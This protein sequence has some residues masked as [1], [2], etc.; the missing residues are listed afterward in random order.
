MVFCCCLICDLAKKTK[1][2]I[3]KKRNLKKKKE[4]KKK[5][6]KKERVERKKERVERKKE[7]NK[8]TTRR[9][10]IK[11]IRITY[12]ISILIIYITLNTIRIFSLV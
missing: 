11:S 8:K 3:H 1:K 7:R 4:K 6:R 9:S 5:E 10:R 2:E 12:T